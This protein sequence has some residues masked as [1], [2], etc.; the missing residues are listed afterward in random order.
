MWKTSSPCSARPLLACN[1]K[2]FLPGP[3]VY[4]A[5]FFPRINHLPG[6]PENFNTNTLLPGLPNLFPSRAWACVDASVDPASSLVKTLRP[7]NYIHSARSPLNAFLTQTRHTH[8]CSCR[9]TATHFSNHKHAITQSY[10]DEHAC[11]C[12]QTHHA[13]SHAQAHAQNNSLTDS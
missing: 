3:S 13:R 4:C 1:D 6:A 5:C 2:G 10:R 8:V 12:F 9:A 7:R 11:A